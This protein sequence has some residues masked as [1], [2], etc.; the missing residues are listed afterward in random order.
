[1]GAEAVA[2]DLL[3]AYQLPA[4]T[5]HR[6]AGRALIAASAPSLREGHREAQGGSGSTIRLASKQIQF[7]RKPSAAPEASSPKAIPLTEMPR[8]VHV[9]E[10]LRRVYP[11]AFSTLTG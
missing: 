8:E 2:Q 9:Q 6:M 3:G 5:A 7:E 10:Q 1:M 11:Q 4:P